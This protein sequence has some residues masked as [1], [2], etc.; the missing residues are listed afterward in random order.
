MTTAPIRYYHG[1]IGPA[2]MFL[3][4]PRSISTS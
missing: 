2:A 1:R 4:I 3:A